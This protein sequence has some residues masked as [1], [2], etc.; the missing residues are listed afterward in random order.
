MPQTR[1]IPLVDVSTVSI[2]ETAMIAA[3]LRIWFGLIIGAVACIAL[4]IIACADLLESCSR[5]QLPTDL[6]DDRALTAQTRPVSKLKE[7]RT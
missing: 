1:Q 3:V 5:R 7:A 2:E 4:L 6:G